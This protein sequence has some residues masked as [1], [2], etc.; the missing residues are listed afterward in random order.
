MANK[1]KPLK[2]NQGQSSLGG[3]TSARSLN[4]PTTGYYDTPL[5]I[6]R[7]IFCCRAYTNK[8]G[9]DGGRRLHVISI[10]RKYIGIRRN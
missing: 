8:C 5:P 6:A 1:K 4:Q 2:E 9:V 10:L 3:R 7:G